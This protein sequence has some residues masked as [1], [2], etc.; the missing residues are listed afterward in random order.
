MSL[1]LDAQVVRVLFH[2]NNV[3]HPLLLPYAQ[4]SYL[5]GESPVYRS[6]DLRCF[7]SG[8]LV[9]VGDYF[10][11]IPGWAYADT[12]TLSSMRWNMFDRVYVT[13]RFF[14]DEPPATLTNVNMHTFTFRAPTGQDLSSYYE[15]FS[16]RDWL[17]VYGPDPVSTIL[18]FRT[19]GEVPL[20]PHKS[21]D[22]EIAVT[23]ETRCMDFWGGAGDYVPDGRVDIYDLVKFSHGWGH[24]SP[25]WTMEDALIMDLNNDGA[26]NIYDLVLLGGVFG[27][28]KGLPPP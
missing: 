20:Y 1:P 19:L 2:Y 17:L 12:F 28:N 7:T 6:L 4:F 21:Y 13:S 27:W 18:Y 9:P 8:D 11:G 24:S 3:Y 25:D 16:K 14:D 22:V 23:L 5:Y 15:C 26:V 10:R